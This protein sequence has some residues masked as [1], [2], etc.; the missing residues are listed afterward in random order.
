MDSQIVLSVATIVSDPI[1]GILTGDF[2][3][4][5]RVDFGDFFLFVDSFSDP[6]PLFD[7]NHDAVL[8]LD[9]FFLFS[10]NFGA[11]VAAQ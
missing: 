4:N 1:E 6:A 8:N 2:D 7:L 3:G 5:G 11:Q 9:D 10:D